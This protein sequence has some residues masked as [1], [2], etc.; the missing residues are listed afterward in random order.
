MRPMLKVRAAVFFSTFL[1]LWLWVIMFPFVL[2]LNSIERYA[3]V[4]AFPSKYVVDI[5]CAPVR[6]FPATSDRP[7]VDKRMGSA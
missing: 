5:F 2:N 1:G 6:S 7:V 3:G 4:Q